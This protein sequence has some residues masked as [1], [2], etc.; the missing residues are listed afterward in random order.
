MGRNQFVK[1]FTRL[2]TEIPDPRYES[3]YFEESRF[4]IPNFLG[5]LSQH[6]STS[7]MDRMSRMHPPFRGES[8]AAASDS[9]VIIRVIAGESAEAAATVPTT[10]EF[11]TFSS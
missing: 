4:L 7:G 1:K 11:L 3:I 10:L 5:E 6:Y 9:D 8:A 2:I